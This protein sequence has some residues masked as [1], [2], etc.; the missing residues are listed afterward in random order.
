MQPSAT[1]PLLERERELEQLDRLAEEACSGLGR[2]VLV[3][4]PPGIGKTRLLGGVR[5]HARE[6][7]MV[8]LS[9]RA[10]ELDREFPFGVVRQLFEPPLASADD[11]QRAKLLH[12]AA[13]LAA[14]LLGGGS[15]RRETAGADPSFAHFHA[16]Y[17]LVANLTEEAA[18][19]LVIDDVHWADASS[20]RFLEFLV[21]RLEELP[22]LVALATR[23]PEPGSDTRSIDALAT[24]PLAHVL[25]PAPLSDPGVAALVAA[26]LG[27]SADPRFSSACHDATGGNPFL[28]R[29]L[30]RELAT[31]GIAPSAEQAP[32]V[33]QL[34]PPTVARAV[35][36]R[37]ARLGDDATALAR[38]V[39]VLGDGAPLRR[40]SPMAGLPEERTGE[41]AATLAQSDILAADRPLAFAHPVLRSAVYADIDPGERGD[42]HR[43]AATLLADEGA[44][45][46]A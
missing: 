46:D 30:L 34:A 21:P 40:V 27:D 31:E 2:L 26:E 43:R 35:L 4:G 29:E 36:L 11:E 44:A 3:E 1:A 8:V 23:P 33:H 14:P 15:P 25:H 37:L 7:E 32:H 12:G 18:A 20:L 39:A 41:L 6:R 38:A 10:S 22:V 17:W 5:V 19:A 16:L 42:A 45:P 9:A 24:D 28:L 13:G